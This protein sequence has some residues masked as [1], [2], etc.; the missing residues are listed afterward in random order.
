MIRF[1]RNSNALFVWIQFIHA[2]HC[3]LVC[4][5]YVD[6]VS[7][8]GNKRVQSVPIADPNILILQRIQHLIMLSKHSQKNIQIR[9]TLKNTMNSKM[10]KSGFCGMFLL[11]KSLNQQLLHLLQLPKT[12]QDN[13]N[14]NNNN[15]SNSSS[16]SKI[17]SQSSKKKNLLLQQEMHLKKIQLGSLLRQLSERKFVKSVRQQ[18]LMTISCVM[19]ILCM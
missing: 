11:H 1:Q 19:R 12:T 17:K 3:N 15:N 4:I 7:M 2:L 9:K 5:I 18:D 14:N 10:K 6:L 8:I 16:K 13:H